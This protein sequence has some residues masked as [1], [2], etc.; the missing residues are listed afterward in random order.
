M[1]V[2]SPFL[3]FLILQNAVLGQSKMAIQINYT[4]LAN[5]F[6]GAAFVNPSYDKA[7]STFSLKDKISELVDVVSINKYMG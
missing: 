4:Q 6:V 1:K 2:F 5:P 3:L 7:T